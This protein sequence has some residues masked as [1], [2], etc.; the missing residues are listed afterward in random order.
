MKDK[1][2]LSNPL[3]ELSPTLNPEELPLDKLHERSFSNSVSLLEGVLIMISKIIEITRSLSECV[4]EC[5]ASTMERCGS[6]AQDVHKQEQVLTR[7][8]VSSE[9]SPEL[10][11][12]LI[13]FPY[14]LERIGDMLESVL[15]CCRT[16]AMQSIHFSEPAHRDLDQFFDSLLTTM[17]DLRDALVTPKRAALEV[18]RADGQ[19]IDLLFEAFREAHWQRLERGVCAVEASSTFRD[20]LDS[21]KSVNEYLVKIGTKMLELGQRG[22]RE[23]DGRE[24]SAGSA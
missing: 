3:Q 24:A 8:I 15:K 10:R 19:R 4:H 21:L 16:K 6:L 23:A 9:V 5:H 7:I 20:I 11:T 1:E 2:V 18:I 17:V 13:N 12:G 22:A 14:R